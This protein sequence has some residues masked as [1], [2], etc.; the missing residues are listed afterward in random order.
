MS[1]PKCKKIVFEPVPSSQQANA[2]AEP[3]PNGTSLL[4]HG[5]F[6][7]AIVHKLK[8]EPGAAG[9]QHRTVDKRA[10]RLVFCR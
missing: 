10:R 7:V 3:I 8:P 6:P 4:V 1:C 9:S 2:C 5:G